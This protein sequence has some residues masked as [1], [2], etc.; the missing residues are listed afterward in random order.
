MAE[1]FG[2]AIRCFYDAAIDLTLTYTETF[3]MGP[4]YNLPSYYASN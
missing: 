2:D 1:N 4:W 3:N